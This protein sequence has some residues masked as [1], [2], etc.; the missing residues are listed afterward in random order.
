MFAQFLT[1]D[2]G[3]ERMSFIWEIKRHL[4]DKTSRENK[5]LRRGDY[6]VIIAFCSHTILLTNY[7]KMDW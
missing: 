1:S 3:N 5:H 6:F 2:D 4:G 7:A